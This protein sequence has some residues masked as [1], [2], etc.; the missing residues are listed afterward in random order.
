MDTNRH[1]RL[2]NDASSAHFYREGKAEASRF[3]TSFYPEE[4]WVDLVTGSLPEREAERLGQHVLECSYC[5]DQ[6]RYW[7]SMLEGEYSGDTAETKPKERELLAHTFCKDSNSAESDWMP[8]GWLRL[9]LRARVRL[10][11]LLRSAR[12]LLSGGRRAGLWIAAS[13]CLLLAFGLLFTQ[14]TQREHDAWG[15]Y[16]QDYEP[17]AATLMSNPNS[18][19]YPIQIGQSGTEFGMLWYNQ[20]SEE[21]LMLVDG[22]V[23]DVNRS[24]RVWA[25]R[26]D[27]RDSLGLLQYHQLRAHLY[28][29]DRDELRRANMLEL[30]IEPV[31]MVHPDGMAPVIQFKLN[32]Q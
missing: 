5:R 18:I 32:Q 29:K 24:V 13:C 4:V 14:Y 12:S 1:N 10:L 16:V 21:L 17:S 27:G 15:Q 22:L 2:S 28:V 9:R 20:G 26:D 31:E 3:C 7:R 23:P 25:V 6:E 19:A 8:S 30:T 11:G